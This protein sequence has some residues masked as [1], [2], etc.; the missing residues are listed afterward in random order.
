MSVGRVCGD[1]KNVPR[2]CEMR[3]LSEAVSLR[4]IAVSQDRKPVPGQVRVHLHLGGAILLGPS[5][6]YA[7]C[8]QRV[9]L[10]G[11]PGSMWGRLAR[12]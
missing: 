12:R 1:R 7:R 9:H 5:Q 6:Q 11:E 10:G 3:P 4:G 2:P 8:V